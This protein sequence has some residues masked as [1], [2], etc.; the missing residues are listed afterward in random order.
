[1]KANWILCRFKLFLSWDKS[2]DIALRGR[3]TDPEA[4]VCLQ[5]APRSAKA[6]SLQR[7]PRW[8]QG[9]QHSKFESV[10]VWKFTEFSLKVTL[11]ERL[12]RPMPSASTPFAVQTMTVSTG[13]M[14]RQVI[15]NSNVENAR[16]KSF[17]LPGLEDGNAISAGDSRGRKI[18][19]RR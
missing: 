11:T 16:R 4:L 18:S 14:L 9:A 3:A 19:T 10:K 8:P 17:Y 2:F 7:R 5:K 6:P 1:M 15:E 12:K 13:A